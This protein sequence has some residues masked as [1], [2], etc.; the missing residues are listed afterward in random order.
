[1][2]GEETYI[3]Y[4]VTLQDSLKRLSGRILNNFQMN[5]LQ[6]VLA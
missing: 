6:S 2:G 4:R 5:S 1:M 3:P